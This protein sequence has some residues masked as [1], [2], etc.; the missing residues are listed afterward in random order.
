MLGVPEGLGSSWVSN[1]LCQL[2]ALPGPHPPPLKADQL[3][4]WWLSLDSQ[5]PG[6]KPVPG[7]G[8]EAHICFSQ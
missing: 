3:V 1:K 7:A 4:P 8:Q 6:C 2:S 5:M